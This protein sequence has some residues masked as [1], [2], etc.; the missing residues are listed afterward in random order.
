MP[1]HE[2][3]KGENEDKDKREEMGTHFRTILPSI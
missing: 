3:W 1:P 2:F